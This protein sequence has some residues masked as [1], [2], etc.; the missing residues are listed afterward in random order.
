MSFSRYAPDGILLAGALRQSTTTLPEA[1]RL[2]LID[3]HPT[4]N[5][6]NDSVAV[7]AVT[8]ALAILIWLGAHVLVRSLGSR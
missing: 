4:Q 7:L 1:P 5:L 8:M 2:R 3:K 6:L